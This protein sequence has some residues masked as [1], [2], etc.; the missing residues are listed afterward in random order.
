MKNTEKDFDI[1]RAAKKDL[2]RVVALMRELA[3]FEEILDEFHV[4]EKLLEQ[5]LFCENP[6]VELLLGRI[7]GEIRGYALYFHNFSS[8]RGRP[9]MYLEDLY[10]DPKARGCG[11]GKALLL[12]VAK[13][14][15]DRGCPRF[16]WVVLDWNERAKQFYESLGANP[17]D[18]WTI[19]RMDAPAI[20]KFVEEG[21]K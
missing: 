16:E 17:L 9:G 21:S 11:L 19:Y 18:G 14:A 15:S 10:V 13:L 1:S 12:E 7:D 4:T 5:Y 2:P 6:I 3:E 8:F 20:Q